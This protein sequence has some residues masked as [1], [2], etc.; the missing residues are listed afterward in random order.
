VAA[1]VARRPAAVA[2]A[3]TLLLAALA[4]F[5][6]GYKA[7]YDLSPYQKGSHAA[8]GYAEL[9]SAFPEGVLTPTQVMVTA[10]KGTLTAGRLAPYTARLAR[11]PDVGD[12]RVVRMSDDAKVAQI[13]MALVIN[14]TGTQALRVH[15]QV[16]APKARALAPAGTSVAVGGLTAAYADTSK[17]VSHDLRLIIPIAA[18]AIGMILLLTLR[19][20]LAPLYLMAAVG[21]GFAATLG[22]AVLLFQHLQHKPGVTFTVPLIVY[23]FVASIGTDYNILMIARLREELLR[24]ASP[25]EAA[26]YAVTHA[27]P[28]VAAAGIILAASFGVL[29][30]SSSTASVGL[31]VAMGVVLAT[32]VTSWL[33]IPALTALVGHRA[34]WPSRTG[35]PRPGGGEHRRVIPAEHPGITS[36]S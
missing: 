15:D 12:A 35:A 20:V 13:D 18:V 3:A 36:P 17:V 19:A 33:L 24:G 5:A 28:S 4:S 11:L 25:R 16:L 34:F 26:R 14:P 32:F 21:L 2:G 27:G 8:Q 22:S 7:D 10:Q 31:P 30:F 29:G 9:K 1:L 6:F 23:L